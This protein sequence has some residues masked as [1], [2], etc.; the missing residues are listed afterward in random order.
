VPFEDKS[1]AA[2]HALG[3]S[4]L[5]RT[6]RDPHQGAPGQWSTTARKGLPAL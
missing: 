3:R 2:G 5:E 4:F 6:G 1:W